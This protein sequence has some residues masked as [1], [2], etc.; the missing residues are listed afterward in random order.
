[1][2]RSAKISDA[3]QVVPLIMIILKDMELPFL[4]KYGEEKVMTVLKKGFSTETYRYSYKRALVVEEEG[5][6]LGVA[7]GYNESEEATIDDPLFPILKEE[8]IEEAE[9]MFTDKEAFENEWYLDSIAV[10]SDQRGRGVGALLLNALPEFARSQGADKLGLSV[11]DANPRAKKLYMREGF[12]EVGRKTIS[13][14]L[15]DHMQKNI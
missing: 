14:H 9:K 3:E 7:F 11:D 10:R 6:I 1:M 2:L 5:E 8:G 12:E 4:L 13:G 15:Y